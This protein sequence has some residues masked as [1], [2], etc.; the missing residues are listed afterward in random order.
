MPRIVARD[1]AGSLF[2]FGFR[3]LCFQARELG[4]EPFHAAH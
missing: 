4:L 2:E 1:L 3:D